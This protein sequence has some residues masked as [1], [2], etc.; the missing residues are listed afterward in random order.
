MAKIIYQP[1]TIERIRNTEGDLRGE[2]ETK[3][4][5]VNGLVAA[6]KVHQTPYEENSSMT[7]ELWD[8]IHGSG[9]VIGFL[10]NNDSNRN[11]T[12]EDRKKNSFLHFGARTPENHFSV[13]CSDLAMIL[14]ASQTSREYVL[15]EGEIQVYDP[16]RMWLHRV[17]LTDGFSYT[18]QLGYKAD[19][20]LA[21]LT[22]K[23]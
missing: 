14:E 22:S 23:R 2:P 16:P 3:F 6:Y 5:S 17:S 11:F 12:K 20:R 18:T 4:V 15:M 1:R 19:E 21:E 7:K 13:E 8:K 10:Y 9:L